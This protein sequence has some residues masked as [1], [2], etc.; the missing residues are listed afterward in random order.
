MNQFLFALSLSCPQIKDPS[1]LG[2]QPGDVIPVEY[3]G[4]DEMDRHSVSRKA[5]LPLSEDKVSSEAI[6][7]ISL[8]IFST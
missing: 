1:E 8:N 7:C 4:I 2:F 6:R 5:L 3:L